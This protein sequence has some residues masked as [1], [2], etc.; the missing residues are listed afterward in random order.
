MADNSTLSSAPERAQQVRTRLRD[1]NTPWKMR[2]YFLSKLPSCWFW[3]VRVESCTPQTCTVSIPY[4]WSSQNPFRST[5]FAALSGAAELSTGLL[6]VL[7]LTGKGKISM[8]ITRFESQFTKKASTRTFF[9]CTAGPEMEAAVDRAIQT[10]LP[11]EITVAATGRN[12]DGETVG[13]MHLT[14][15]FKKKG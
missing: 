2:L 14:W 7:A 5:Y 3:G 9:T 1:F 6:A 13:E 15:S 12:A 4:R 8:L 10:G 11:Q